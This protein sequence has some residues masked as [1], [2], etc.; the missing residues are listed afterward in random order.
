MKGNC[1]PWVGGG[2][3]L[4]R[5]T[6]VIVLRDLHLLFD[7]THRYYQYPAKRVLSKVQSVVD[8]RLC[9]QIH[10]YP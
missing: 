3:T 7:P 2:L 10:P 6:I 8:K 9:R 1:P 5:E 4:S